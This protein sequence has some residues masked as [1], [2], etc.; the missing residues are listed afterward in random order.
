MSLDWPFDY[1]WHFL[2][3]VEG[4]LDLDWLYFCLV[5]FYF[6]VFYAISVDFDW[7]FFYD[8][9]G[10]QL[11]H[12][13]FDWFLHLHSYL[14]Y[15]LYLHCFVLFFLHHYCF[16]DFHFD[17]H[18]NCLDLDLRDWNFNYLQL[19]NSF[20]NYFFNNFGH[21]NYLLHYPGDGHDFLHYFLNLD[22]AG[23]FHY[24][25]NDSVDELRLNFHYLFFNNDRHCLFHFDG[26][27]HFLPGCNNL[28]LFNF[29]LPD[30]LRDEGGFDFSL[31]WNFLSDEEGHN[32][33][34]FHIFGDQNFLDE[35]FIDKDLNLP[36]LFFLVTFDEVR[37]V[38]VDLL[39]HFPDE[40]LLNFKF[41]FNQFFKGV[42]DDNRFVSVLGELD[43]LNFRFFDLDGNLGDNF[44]C[45]LI[46]DDDG[47]CLLYFNQ[48]SF[49]DDVRNSNFDGFDYLLG[50]Y[51]RDNFFNSFNN[52]N[53]FLHFGL[54]YSLYLFDFNVSD[55]FVDLDF[56]CY[57]FSFHEW[58]YFLNFDGDLFGDFDYS[59]DD[60]L[61][62]G[63]NLDQFIRVDLDGNLFVD[64][65]FDRFLDVDWNLSGGSVYFLLFLFEYGWF[66]GVERYTF[67][68]VHGVVNFV[69][70]DDGGFD[71][72]GGWPEEF[73]D[74]IDFK[75]IALLLK[76]G[77]QSSIKGKLNAV[78]LPDTHQ[79]L[80]KFFQHGLQMHDHLQLLGVVVDVDIVNSHHAYILHYYLF[81]AFD[82]GAFDEL[83]EELGLEELDYF[84]G[85][86]GL[87]FGELQVDSFELACQDADQFSKFFLLALDLVDSDAGCG[88]VHPAVDVDE[89]DAFL[90]EF[91]GEPV[92]F[93]S[94][95][96][97]G[98]VGLYV[99]YF[100]L[101]EG[102]DIFVVILCRFCPLGHLELI[103]EVV[104]SPQ[105]LEVVDKAD[106]SISLPILIE[107]MLL[108]QSVHFPGHAQYQ[109]PGVD[110]DL[111]VDDP[112]E[113]VEVEVEF[114]V[115][116][117]HLVF[118]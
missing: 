86:V 53:Q 81:Q 39:G 38:D 108:Q 100:V 118:E 5:D 50:L 15:L 4:N 23:D 42:G 21:F 16:L 35:G 7:H 104:N 1:E 96:E 33:L 36:D 18:L 63:G 101:E 73:Y 65:H 95:F 12:F 45:V 46:F 113:V 77:D 24:L 79:L 34:C 2:L 69:L 99:L 68:V 116:G 59:L 80:Q 25:L 98:V 6:L 30:F 83:C 75:V 47:N 22:Y 103:S 28:N 87:Q 89:V 94:S 48:L 11:F 19:T 13:N 76:H 41:N 62:G 29:N 112:G 110:L 55:D 51:L 3:D 61:F 111:F 66:L 93:L 14:N 117:E 88:Q 49:G 40:F 26:F 60:D 92:K 37:A 43:N 82:G 72:P 85:A 115:G 102:K 57:F 106:Y 20:H 84:W 109:G 44:N 9:V 105:S 54:N 17:G 70:D 78:F 90:L 31:N 8:F 67:L 64:L 107:F 56:P 58:D 32:F 10:D 27:D 71:V 114:L 97:V 74:S 91:S 52:F